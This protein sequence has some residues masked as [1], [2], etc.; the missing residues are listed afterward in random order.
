M[1]ERM[2]L[3]CVDGPSMLANSMIHRLSVNK[4]KKA[5]LMF[6]EP[7]FTRFHLI[8]GIR[9]LHK[10]DIYQEL[11]PCSLLVDNFTVDTPAEAVIE[12][13]D[14]IFKDSDLSRYSEI[15]CCN[16]GWGAHINL[17]FNLKKIPYV[18]LQLAV[19]SLM[20]QSRN[21]NI[22][23]V[24]KYKA[25]SPFAEFATPCLLSDS[26]VSQQELKEKPFLTW[27]LMECYEQIGEDIFEKIAKSFALKLPDINGGTL[28]L[29]NSVPFLYTTN[30]TIGV[31]EKRYNKL[32][33]GFEKD[34]GSALTARYVDKVALDYY[35]P[36]NRGKL[37]LKYHLYDYKDTQNTRQF[38]NEDDES[39]TQIPFQFMLSFLRQNHVLFDNVI[40][41]SSTSL[42]ILQK[43]G[44]M[45]GKRQMFLGEGFIKSWYYYDSI[46]VLALYVVQ[47]G[48]R[49]VYA[50][51]VICGQLRNLMQVYPL[52]F[53]VEQLKM[54]E[55]KKL[56]KSVIIVN[57]LDYNEDELQSYMQLLPNDSSMVFLNIDIAEYFFE[58]MIMNYFAPIVIKKEK[59]ASGYKL[60]ETIRDE[61][62]WVF[63][64]QKTMRDH[65]R[66]LSVRKDL[67][68][69]GAV[70]Y[71]EPTTLAQ[72]AMLFKEY[73]ARY[74]WK[75][76]YESLKKTAE[77]LAAQQRWMLSAISAPLLHDSKADKLK[78]LLCAEKDFLQYLDLLNILKDRFVILL[79]IRDT[80]GNKL[81]ACVIEKLKTIGFEHFEKQLWR[82]Y[83]GMIGKGLVICDR[84]GQEAEEPVSFSYLDMGSGTKFEL[85]SEAWR[86]GNRGSICINDVE[87][88]VNMR[89]I[90]LV[91]YDTD[92]QQVVDSVGYDAH[93]AEKGVFRR[94]KG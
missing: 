15:Y 59:T 69:S 44:N 24:Q 74:L 84:A 86:R 82:M 14:R 61:I 85:S 49:T 70:M 62:I 73:E 42:Q 71:T 80:P 75:A 56:H 87:Y 76:H 78:E 26:F 38:Y 27:N 35:C 65:A 16:D 60:S 51:D 7:Q 32:L 4:D 40:G 92:S 21:T 28:L 54:S 22:R 55:I 37:Y 52:D 63:T 30:F 11:I 18:W 36:E 77:S 89:G 45:L 31:P 48:I 20:R 12:H 47:C 13:F 39:L 72:A 8:D 79:V 3:Y 57:T 19:D 33:M 46:Y 41:Y 81:T 94:L 67:P 88:C 1:E 17:Y 25:T 90:N 9:N 93:T 6:N 64:Q 23:L 68:N 5:V 83:A 43:E 53:H 50:D 29:R 34:T 2:V 58:E 66:S 91:V 10:Y